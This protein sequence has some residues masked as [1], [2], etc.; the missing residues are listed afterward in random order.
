MD[1]LAFALFVAI[2]CGGLATVTIAMIWIAITLFR[3]NRDSGK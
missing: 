3:K 2:F 1:H